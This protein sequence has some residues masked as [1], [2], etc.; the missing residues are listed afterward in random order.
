MIGWEGIYGL[1]IS[2]FLIIP[3]NFIKINEI[4]FFNNPNN[5]IEDINDAIIQIFNNIYLILCH[6]FF[7][8]FII[9]ETFSCKYIIKDASCTGVIII[10]NIN[11]IFIWILSLS[12]GWEYFYYLE[13]IALIILFFGICIYKNIVFGQ[14]YRWLLVKML[15]RHDDENEEVINQPADA[16]NI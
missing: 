15:R 14:V 6:L 5:V 16:V 1:L 9:L 2:I 13:L 8:I 3:M 11:V 10:Q 12:L 7:I 4:P